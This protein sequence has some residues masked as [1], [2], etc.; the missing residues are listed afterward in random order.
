[1]K[2]KFVIS[3]LAITITITSFL[4]LNKNISAAPNANPIF[5]TIAYVQEKI[6]ELFNQLDPRIQ[7]NESDIEFL[8]DL[9][10]RNELR[11]FELEG[12]TE[13]LESL[14]TPTPTPIPVTI[15]EDNFDGPDL[16]TDI[17]EVFENNGNYHFDN[18]FIVVP[19][20]G[21]MPFFRTKSNPFPE[22]GSFK[23]EFGFQYLTPR[24]GGDGVTLSFSQQ[25]NITPGW[26]NNPISVWQDSTQG[27]RILRYGNTAAFLASEDIDY[28]V[29]RIVYNE[30]TYEVFI[31]GISVYV[32][33]SLGRAGG[34]WF[35]HPFYCCPTNGVWT[36]FKL[37]FIKVTDL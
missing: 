14:L 15:L 11:I 34:L 25:S 27:F 32:S 19:G 33:D 35:G 22:T 4:L 29:A 1:M 24:G 37:D 23:V 3:F 18:G 28:H 9:A 36:G 31:D 8:R 20:N 6:D 26:E 12:R 30:D 7:Q 21:A 17:W 13:F 16:N 5:A 10:G 2:K